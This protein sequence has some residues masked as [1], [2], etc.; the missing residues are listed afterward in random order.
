MAGSAGVPQALCAGQ[1]SLW[2]LPG[3]TRWE[4]CE[5]PVAAGTPFRDARPV[6]STLPLQPSFS[7]LGA[8]E[9]YS[10][11]GEAERASALPLRALLAESDQA[12]AAVFSRAHFE[13]GHFTASGLVLSPD[14]QRLLLIFHKKLGLWLQPGGHFEKSDT[15]FLE[16][17]MREVQ[18]ET[19]VR[20][21]ELLVPLLD[22]DVHRIP[23]FGDEPAHLHHDL[24]VLFRSPTDLVTATDEVAA[25]RWFPLEEV[26]ADVSLQTDASVRRCARRVLRYLNGRDEAL[27][28]AGGPV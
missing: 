10:Q 18:E 27:S 14:S 22:V 28:E 25:A 21:C 1:Y 26:E 15:G 6:M 7:L 24:R 8:L 11:W 3:S 5:G 2:R 13:P 20:D 9:T 16:A 12:G 23:Q 17:A 19:G 4:R